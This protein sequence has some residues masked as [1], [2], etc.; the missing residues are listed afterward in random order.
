MS[1]E[2]SIIKHQALSEDNVQIN[3]KM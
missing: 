2:R 1:L 3:I